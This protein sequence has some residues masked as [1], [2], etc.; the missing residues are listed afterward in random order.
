[1]IDYL[2]AFQSPPDGIIGGPL[3]RQKQHRNLSMRRA[4]GQTY[5]LSTTYRVIQRYFLARAPHL[6]LQ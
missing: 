1:M 6:V 5:K 4:I 3:A 2:L